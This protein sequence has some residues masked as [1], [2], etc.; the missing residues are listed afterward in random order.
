MIYSSVGPTHVNICKTYE[1]Y[2]NASKTINYNVTWINV[3]SPNSP[4]NISATLCHGM[5]FQKERKWMW[6]YACMTPP[7]DVSTLCSF[8]GSV[9]FYGMFIPNLASLPDH[10]NRLLS[11]QTPWA[12]SAQEQEG[13]QT[14]KY[15]LGKD[16]VLVHF[17]PALQV[18]ISCDASNVGIGVVLFHCYPD[19]SECPISNFSKTLTPS[20]HCYRAN[21]RRKHWWRFLV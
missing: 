4:W 6:L 18:G 5:G 21:Y 16:H 3:F 12:W 20:Q 15:D 8:W 17:D 1:H 14:F 19:G 13:F 2:Y 11:R 7:S 9:Q 10:L